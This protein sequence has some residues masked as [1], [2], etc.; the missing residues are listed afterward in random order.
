MGETTSF[1][2]LS[3]RILDKEKFIDFQYPCILLTRESLELFPILE[4][5]E[6]DTIF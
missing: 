5:R 1:K 4:T 6:I 3:R 2:Q